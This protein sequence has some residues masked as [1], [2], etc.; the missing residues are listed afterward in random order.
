MNSELFDEWYSNEFIPKVKRGKWGAQVERF[1]VVHPEQ[2][3]RQLKL[4]QLL[5]IVPVVF[6]SQ[7][8]INNGLPPSYIRITNCPFQD[9]WTRNVGP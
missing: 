1:H 7:L 6:L 9:N 3:P 5:A 8:T 2:C 4:Y